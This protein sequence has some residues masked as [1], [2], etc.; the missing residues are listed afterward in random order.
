MKW[1]I[2]AILEAFDLEAAREPNNPIWAALGFGSK[3]HNLQP[4]WIEYGS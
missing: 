3:N 1:L 4:Y 2:L